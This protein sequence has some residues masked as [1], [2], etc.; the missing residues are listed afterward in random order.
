MALVRLGV[1]C[2]RIAD[3]DTFEIV[4]FNRQYGADVSTIDA[5]SASDGGEALAVNPQLELEIFS[6]AINADNAARFLDGVDVLLDGIDFFAFD[7][8]ASPLSR[9]RAAPSGA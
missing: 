2:F 7:A 8:R 1:G 9:G 6:E 4:N 5:P 3:P